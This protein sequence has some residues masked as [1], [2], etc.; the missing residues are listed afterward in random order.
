MIRRSK[1]LK[2]ILSSMGERGEDNSAVA[3][4]RELLKSTRYNEELGDFDAVSEIIL[5]RKLLNDAKIDIVGT[6]AALE[7]C[8]VFLPLDGYIDKKDKTLS[9]YV[10]AGRLLLPPHDALKRYIVKIEEEETS[11]LEITDEKKNELN[12]ILR[13]LGV[14]VDEDEDDAPNDGF[15]QAFNDTVGEILKRVDKVREKLTSSV[16]GQDHAISAFLGGYFEAEMI[17]KNFDSR[18]KPR[19]T[20]L[21]AGPPGVGKTFLAEQAAAA[22]ELPFL[23]LDMSN[24][25]DRD[26]GDMIQGVEA[27]YQGARPGDLTGFVYKNP[28]SVILLDEVEKASV[29]VI[30]LLLQLL[31]AGRLRDNCLEKE[32][33]FVD[34][35]VIL[36]TNAGKSMYENEDINLGAVS[37]KSVLKAIGE[38]E[39]FSS[40]I[41]SRFASGNVV[42]FN[43][44]KAEYLAEISKKELEVHVAAIAEKFNLDIKLGKNVPYAILFSAGVNVDART[45]KGRSKSF[46][47]KELY[48]F[49]HL[50]SSN[51]NDYE[52]DRIKR[53]VVD[54]DLSEDEKIVELFEG[55]KNP[56]ILLFANKEKARFLP[57]DRSIKVHVAESMEEAQSI[58]D[59][60][61]ISMI[62]CDLT[63]KPR[64]ERNMLNIEDFSSLGVDFFEYA[65]K[66]TDIPLYV[67][68][69]DKRTLSDEELDTLATNG[70][71]GVVYLYETTER[72]LLGFLN[73]A[74]LQN[75]ML[76]LGRS[77]KVLYYNSLQRVSGS[78]EKGFI[79]MSSLSLNTSLDAQDSGSVVSEMT[80]PNVK[81][82]DV[83]GASDAKDELKYF[84]N[85]LKNPAKYLKSG[86]KPPKGALLYG[87][88]GTGKTLLAKAMAGESGVTF[89]SCEGN[90]FLNKWVGV[91]SEKVH[92]VFRT[93]RKYA[94]SIVFVDEIDVIAK[95]RGGDAETSHTD[96]V[97]TAFLSEM[98]G[99]RSSPA[100]PVFI[101]AATNKDATDADYGIDPALLRRF[102]RKIYVGLPSVDD[103]RAFL[104]S[105]LGKLK[106]SRVSAETIENIVKRSISMSLA[107]LDTVVELAQ[108][109]SVKKETFVITDEIFDEAFETSISGESKTRD[110]KSVLRTARHEAGH[111]AMSII[112]GE[113]PSY[114]TIVSRGSHGGYMM[115]N[116]DEN[117]GSYTKNE[118]LNSIKISLAGRAAERLY[119]GEEDGISTG[120]SEDLKNAS[121][122]A[123]SMFA[124][125]GMD[126]KNLL[127][128]DGITSRLS[129]ELLKKANDLLVREMENVMYALASK[130]ALI[131]ALVEKLMEKNSLKADEIEKIA[132]EILG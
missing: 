90:Q 52:V 117:K 120:P 77:N 62:L 3:F 95:S 78:G 85:Y 87:P 51:N 6:I 20:F 103:R 12:S 86:V 2:L 53:V 42:M 54:V 108:R 16:I 99:F 72:E 55:V 31:D 123:V 15:A 65:T 36:T 69:D 70:M 25:S 21:F 59:E 58:L 32:V 38:E 49:F 104:V 8:D 100:R 75:K 41:C 61:V 45:I 110:E 91:G 101:L 1:L 39:N 126:P 124:R 82:E 80:K 119:Y 46:V 35:V 84:I 74:H 125:Y 47:Y 129:P 7:D 37:S 94:P 83:I 17:A 66:F 115:R 43:R 106:N 132:K 92:D 56:E 33:S 76:E 10:L 27:K 111:A 13:S 79:L 130:R 44:M 113:Y 102:D 30:H 5:V 88:P 118:L 73:A 131:D 98:D 60:N 96:D 109:L 97:L 128:V 24:Y 22:L 81:F 112:C 71:K 19:A 63:H 48:E 23:R 107:E 34:T 114:L 50:L 67:L 40:A 28:R 9:A 116:V 127:S 29:P 93:A 105:R 14:D 122:V 57:T 4:L 68:A 64:E 11:A 121:A 26:G 89:L 18:S